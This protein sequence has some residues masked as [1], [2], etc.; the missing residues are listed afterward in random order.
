MSLIE[1]LSD[2]FQQIILQIVM[3][4]ITSTF[5]MLT[6]TSSGVVV[7]VLV[8]W[9]FLL[10]ASHTLSFIRSRNRL[11]ELAYI[12]EGLDK[13]YLFC[14]CVPK[15]KA[16]YE[17]RLFILMKKSC[18]SMIEAV[19]DAEVVQREYREYIE[20]WVHEIKAPITT[21][22]LICQGLEG[23][24]RRRLMFQLA[25]VETNVER[26]LFCARA[27]SVE[28]DFIIR[29]N[30][31]SD[32]VAQAVE[33]HRDLLIQSG[34]RVEMTG[35]DVSV[36]TD[37]KWTTF[38]LG[39]LLQNAVRY[40]SENPVIIFSAYPIGE[41]VQ[42]EIADNGIGIPAY[43]ISRIFDRGFTGNNG[44]SRGGATGM[45]LYICH[46]LAKFLEIDISAKSVQNE[47]TV[48]TLILPSK[49]YLTKMKD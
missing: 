10:S 18:K 41:R 21:A 17:K 15:P 34:A 32:I 4:V 29:E 25:Q 24:S 11:N 47:G 2:R 19:S 44:R 33:K 48:I 6:G 45:G 30:N 36:Y 8:V 37:H 39:Q 13:K 20:S 22:E 49:S 28:K 14:E 46:R 3:L 12:M 27:E 1:F 23:D 43:E 16:A 40:K 31:L 42:L 35:V 5:L 38:M 9:F 7:I 26:A